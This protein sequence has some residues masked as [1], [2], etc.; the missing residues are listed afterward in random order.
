MRKPD[1]VTE[2]RFRSAAQ[3]KLL[4][5]KLPESRLSR[6]LVSLNLVSQV[7]SGS[8][9]DLSLSFYPKSLREACLSNAKKKVRNS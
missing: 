6:Y 7:R 9:S 1:R 3:H 5:A 4:R 8:V 2:S